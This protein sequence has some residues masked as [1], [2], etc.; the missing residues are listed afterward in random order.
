[1]MNSISFSEKSQVDATERLDDQH[2]KLNEENEAL[3][4][5]I[6]ELTY[7]NDQLREELDYNKDLLDK[8]EEE[9]QVIKL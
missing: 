9:I 1:M 7:T 6:E 8:K 4:E 5:L 3:K 2:R